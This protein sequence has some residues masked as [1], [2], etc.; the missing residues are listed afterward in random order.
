MMASRVAPRST[1]SYGRNFTVSA[2]VEK[3]ENF[4][5]SENA[6]KHAELRQGCDQMQAPDSEAQLDPIIQRKA[7]M[8]FQ[9]EARSTQSM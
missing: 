5:S 4:P 9:G 8:A 6:R 3:A 7:P 2:D 1:L